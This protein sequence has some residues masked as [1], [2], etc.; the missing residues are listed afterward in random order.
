MLVRFTKH[1]PDADADGLICVR[2]DGT[3]TAGAMRRRGILPH[4]AIHFVV[5]ATLGWHDAVFGRVARGEPLDAVTAKLHRP[6]GTWAKMT[7]AMQTEALVE[8]LEAEHWNG[9]SNPADFAEALI[10]GCRRRGAT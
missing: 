1:A 2:P 8:A 3:T 4:E 6:G 9:T 10:T 5:E 7:Q